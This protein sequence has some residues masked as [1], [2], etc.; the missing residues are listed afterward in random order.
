MLCTHQRGNAAAGPNVVLVREV[1]STK[2]LTR[3]RPFLEVSSPEGLG[4]CLTCPVSALHPLE[5]AC[6]EADTAGMAKKPEPQKPIVWSIY[7]IA[8]K[9]VWLGEVEA[10]DEREAIS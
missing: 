3:P 8:S 5:D 7:K 2:R 10:A 1:N 6:A 9:A 4:L